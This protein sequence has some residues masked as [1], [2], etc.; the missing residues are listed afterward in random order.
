MK[1]EE[2]DKIWSWVPNGGPI[3]RLIGRLT[4]GRKKNSNS[5]WRR[6]FEDWKEGLCSLWRGG[7]LK[8]CAT[9]NVSRETKQHAV[10]RLVAVNTVPNAE[11][12]WIN[13]G[14]TNLVIV[15]FNHFNTWDNVCDFIN[16]LKQRLLQ[17]CGIFLYFQQGVFNNLRPHSTYRSWT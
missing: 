6:V 15:T 14:Y 10:M 1:E 12:Y 3:P 16:S 7:I 9:I 5:K 8:N 13:S 11:S 4:V 17:H 2:E